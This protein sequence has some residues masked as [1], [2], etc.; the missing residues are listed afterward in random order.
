MGV[1]ERAKMCHIPGY[2]GERRGSCVRRYIRRRNGKDV[3]VDLDIYEGDYGRVWDVNTNNC[4]AV[5][6]NLNSKVC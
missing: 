1:K 2:S 5:L 3:I 6:V 4:P